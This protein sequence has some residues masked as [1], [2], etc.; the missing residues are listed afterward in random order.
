MDT[1]ALAY[2]EILT[3][4]CTSKHGRGSHSEELSPKKDEVALWTEKESSEIQRIVTPR[5]QPRNV[6]RRAQ[7]LVADVA[8]VYGKLAPPGPMSTPA[9]EC[10]PRSFK[11]AYIRVTERE[12]WKGKKVERRRT[13]EEAQKATVKSQESLRSG[14]ALFVLQEAEARLYV[15]VEQE[16]EWLNGMEM[17]DWWCMDIYWTKGFQFGEAQQPSP[18][19]MN[20]ELERLKGVVRADSWT[21][22]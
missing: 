4:P 22:L 19:T 6:L 16:L 9:S 17:D 13:V 7:S 20:Q 14:R 10:S 15:E 11:R 5:R 1:N 18:L 21:V 12:E 3:P 2:K 8:K